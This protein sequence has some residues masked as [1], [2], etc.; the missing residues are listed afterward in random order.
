MYFAND[1]RA[2]GAS[3]ASTS[4]REFDPFSLPQAATPERNQKPT[5]VAR[6]R[7]RHTIAMMKLLLSL[8]LSLSAADAATKI[9]VIEVG[10]GGTVHRTTSTTPQTSVDGA[11]S[12]MQ[13]MHGR[14]I[15]HAGM[16]VVPDLFKKADSGV[17]IGVS[18]SAVDFA[19]MPRV[20]EL[21]DEEKN[22]VIGHMD[23]PGGRS[24]AIMSKVGEWKDVEDISGA[25]EEAKN[26]GL[27]GVKVSIDESKLSAFDSSI[28][29]LISDIDT[30]AK[31]DGKTVILY[32]VVEE[33]EAVARRRTLT[34]RRLEE[35]DVN[36][37]NGN[38][39]GNGGGDKAGFY[40]YGYFNDYGEWVTPYKTMF[41]IQYFNIVLWTAIGLS[42]VLFSTIYMMM[43]M[44]LEPDTL[45]FGESAKMVGDD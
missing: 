15:Q 26:T 39:G 9:A 19:E 31:K 7:R 20:A 43:F 6:T 18:G 27:S 21:F 44:P 17:V 45:L 34:S 42:V 3:L 14:K 33:E 11:I 35:Q 1:C 13:A 32:L 36:E 12:F 16:T 5:Q 37:Y 8:L 23:I 28:H 4:C 25:T 38:Q 29:G 2:D 10:V 22:G 40:G 24:N 30:Q 41:Q